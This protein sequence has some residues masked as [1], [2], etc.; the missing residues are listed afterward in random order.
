MKLS[1]RLCTIADMIQEGKVL[2]DVGTD[3]GYIPITMV[4][5]GV[6]EQAIAMDVRKGPLERA[7]EHIAGEGLTD[8]ITTRLSDG[9]EKL[10][11]GEA[12]VVVIA[13]MGGELMMRILREGEDK[14]KACSYLILQP[15]SELEEFRRFLWEN[16][17]SILEERMVYEDGKYYPMMKVSSKGDA[18]ENK[19]GLLALVKKLAEGPEQGAIQKHLTLAELTHDPE[20]S[21]QELVA[22]KYGS[23]LILEKNKALKAYVEKEKEQLTSIM[24]SLK[25]QEKS[26]KILRRIDEVREKIYYNKLVE[27]LLK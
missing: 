10:K 11:P 23:Y 15:Q 26:E 1:Q 17:Y 16:Q 27:M 19:K 13:G 14:A 4:K 6:V 5:S 3:H 18:S 24:E 22:E 20:L 7:Q 9:L 12:D 8:K 25:Q 21:W 2:C